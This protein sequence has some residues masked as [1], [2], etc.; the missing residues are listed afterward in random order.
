LFSSSPSVEGFA[1][2]RD[3]RVIR[4]VCKNP[5]FPRKRFQNFTQY[6]SEGQKSVPNEQQPRQM[7]RRRKTEMQDKTKKAKKEIKVRDLKPV[8]DAKGGF[9]PGPCGPS[10]SGPRPDEP[11]GPPQ[12]S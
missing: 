11:P 12:R 8:K 10:R 6:I 7:N 2:I 5:N 3:I 1:L 9:P 4:G